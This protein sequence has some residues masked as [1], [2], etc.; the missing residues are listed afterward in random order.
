MDNKDLCEHTR[1]RLIAAAIGHQQCTK[2]ASNIVPIPGSDRVIAIGTPAQVRALLP[3]DTAQP[4]SATGQVGVDKN[5][6]ELL[7]ELEHAIGGYS[8]GPFDSIN[9]IIQRHRAAPDC[10]ACPGD[11]SICKTECRHRGENPPE[12]ATGT[13]GASVDTLEFRRLV[14]AVRHAA[15]NFDGSTPEMDALIAH[16]DAII[17]DLRAQLAREQQLYGERRQHPRER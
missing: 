17:G 13:T 7:D 8:G 11:G 16:I 6:Q 1:I 5:R 9:E 3:V 2:T 15:W 14:M 12:S 10:G 4:E